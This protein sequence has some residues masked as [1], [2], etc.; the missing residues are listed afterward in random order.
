MWELHGLEFSSWE[1]VVLP[2][3][4]CGRWVNILGHDLDRLNLSEFM[5]YGRLSKAGG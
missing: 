3:V 4:R 2:E 1:H 5:A